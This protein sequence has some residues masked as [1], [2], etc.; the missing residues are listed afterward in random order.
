MVKPY[1]QD[2]LDAAHR[3]PVWWDMNGVPRFE[4]CSPDFRSNIYSTQI[5]LI[6]AACQACGTVFCGSVE[7]GGGK[8]DL[9]R[10]CD[11]LGL[12]N[13]YKDPPQNECCSSGY[14]MN[15]ETRE[16]LE[17]WVYEVK[18]TPETMEAEGYIRVENTLWYRDVN[19]VARL[20][21]RLGVQ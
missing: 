10:T 2:I 19:Y 18:Q 9:R 20:N 3:P 12:E 6:K 5:C 14:S 21:A 4:A 17:F 15:S 13:I 16:V 11:G 8:E 1:Y 7:N